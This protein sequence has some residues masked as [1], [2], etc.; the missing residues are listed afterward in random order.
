MLSIINILKIILNL[1]KLTNF[2]Q[3]FNDHTELT[4]SISNMEITE[5]WDELYFEL[6][7]T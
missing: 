6:I 4:C 7:Y 2:V 1:L 5:M 3:Y